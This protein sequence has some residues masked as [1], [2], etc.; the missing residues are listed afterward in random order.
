M[1]GLTKRWP[2]VTV[3]DEFDALVMRGDK[4]A[5]IGRNGVGKTTLCKLL[6]GEL[7]S[8]SGT[9]TWGHEAQVGYLAQDHREGIALGTTVAEWLHDIDPRA[10]MKTSAASWGECSSRARR[11]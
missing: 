4:I 2:G 6:L 7:P 9:V 11:G 1:E 3:C 5:V 10:E 8:D